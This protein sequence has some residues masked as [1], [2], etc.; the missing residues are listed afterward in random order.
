M[1]GWLFAKQASASDGYVCVACESTNIQTLAP[2]VYHCNTCGTDG[3][4]ALSAWQDQRARTAYNNWSVAQLREHAAAQLNEA[5]CALVSAK[6][7]EHAV[8]R[9]TKGLHAASITLEAL[10]DKGVTEL[11]ATLVAARNP[12]AD[13]ARL[14][15]HFDECLDQIG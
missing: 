8:F 3:G 11:E 5:R 7:N 1:L 6:D 9:A 14:Q 2:Q 10:V 12:P 4:S 13:I 15:N